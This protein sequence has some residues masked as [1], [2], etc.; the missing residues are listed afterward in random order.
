MEIS[1][2]NVTK[3]YRRRGQDF[4][5]IEKYSLD[6]HAGE[7]IAIIG[8]SGSGKTT[9]LHLLGGILL[10][11]EGC[12][13]YDAATL[14]NL[15]EAKQAAFKNEKIGFIPQGNSLI[16]SLTVL[17]NLRLPLY[18]GDREHQ[19]GEE[20]NRAM[21]LLNALDIGDLADEYPFNLS[22][23]EQRRVAVARALMNRPELILADEPTND[24]DNVSQAKVM[25]LLSKVNKNGAT[26]VIVTHQK[27]NLDYATQVIEMS[28]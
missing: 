20:I 1:I 7:F 9:F 27:E 15:S 5:A 8:P 2:E 17:D 25:Q 13:H 3:T 4:A 19:V 22:G 14:N 6:I 18:L 12:I 16:S 26:V 28:N 23:G 24:L 21:E 11:N 10:P